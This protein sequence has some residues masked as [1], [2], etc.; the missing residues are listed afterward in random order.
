[1]NLPEVR[2]HEPS[3]QLRTYLAVSVSG[4]WIVRFRSVDC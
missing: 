2:M 3:R 1:M 4:S